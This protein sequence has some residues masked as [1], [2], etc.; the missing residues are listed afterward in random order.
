MSAVSSK[1]YVA[2]SKWWTA[3][4][5]VCNLL[6]IAL[7]LIFSRKR[8]ITYK[9]LLNF[10]KGKTSLKSAFSIVVLT[11]AVG[12]G[13]LFLSGLICYG[14]FPYLDKTLVQPLPLWLA[15]TVL[16][17]LPMTTT[18]AEDGLYLGYGVNICGETDAKNIY[19][20]A[21]FYAFQH[22]F[23]PFLPDIVFIIYR[24]ISFLP[25]TFIICFL[26]RKNK[27]PLPFMAGHFLLNVATAVQ[28]L[29]MTLFPE[30]YATL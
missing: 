30:L 11:I 21:F 28:I 13:G 9:T 12:M 2:V 3:V 23:I 24:F 19:L 22:S 25:L 8:G 18:L 6:T 16:I 26:Y 1:S 17:L 20:S 10:E 29:V 4:A 15:I 14:T 27:H 5:V 7:L